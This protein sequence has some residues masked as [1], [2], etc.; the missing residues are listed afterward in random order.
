MKVLLVSMPWA[1]VGYPSLALGILKREA[2]SQGR[3]EIETVYANLDF[4]D[5]ISERASLSYRAYEYFS[6]ESYFLGLGDWI[7]SSALY[8]DP[9]W[10][11]SE[12]L[13]LARSE[14]APQEMIDL[15]N[16]L[17]VLAPVFIE[18]LARQVVAREPDIVGFTSTFQQNTASL[19]AAKAVKK[20]NPAVRTIFG[21]ANCDGPQGEALHRNFEFVDFVVCGE[22]EIAFRSL[23][24]ALETGDGMSHIGGLCWRDGDGVQVSNGMEATPKALPSS[25][26][27]DFDEYFAR[28]SSS[29]ARRWCEPKLVLEGSRGCWWGEKHHCTF[30][31]LNGSGMQFRQKSGQ[32]LASELLELVE[33]HNVLDVSLTDNILDPEYMHSALPILARRGYDLRIHCEIKSNM[34][35]SQLEAL[36]RSGVTHVQPGIESLSTNVLK[37]MNK[38]V[39]ACLNVR[40]L[41]D[42]ESVGLQAEWN[43]L[44]GFP[45][46]DEGDYDSVV[47]QIPALY[48]LSPPT[49]AIR[50]VIER[51]SPYFDNESL[52]F[53]H[54]KPAPQY[55]LTYDLPGAELEEMAYLFESSPCGVS[56]STIGK[57]AE[58]IAEWR[59]SYYEGKRM[60]Y[61]EVADS[62]V[63]V[64]TRNS[65]DWHSLILDDLAEKEIFRQLEQPR[66][67]GSLK[68]VAN[69]LGS[70]IDVGDLMERW[71]ALGLVFADSGQFI[72]VAV[73]ARNQELR[74]VGTEKFR[75]S[76]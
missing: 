20:A 5:W 51:F 16:D 7:F 45:G 57:L 10:R 26:P 75:V 68:R 25:G 35:R 50:I 21:G 72:H 39:T 66:S 49:D 38:G 67:V 65:Y 63:L 15:A 34:R 61:C 11:V 46:E 73:E 76:S 55:A 36:L 33:R 70:S 43:Y 18:D 47:A 74:R 71:Q 32:T 9:G 69:D 60:T 1:A 28:L 8:D 37:I 30:C 59:R 22:G 4:V 27:P 41:R 3:A 13:R 58:L 14:G 23:I 42:A 62:I 64:N 17:H 12:F 29:L 48:H 53:A 6:D 52:G 2:A 40:M 19:A 56:D 54:L 31:G 24:E 44:C